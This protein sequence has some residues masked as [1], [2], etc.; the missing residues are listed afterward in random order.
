MAG[1]GKY[2]GDLLLIALGVPDGFHL[3]GLFTGHVVKAHRHG[4]AF[5][6]P[7]HIRHVHAHR[8]VPF[9]AGDDLAQILAFLDLL[10]RLDQ[11]I[12][13]CRRQAGQFGRLQHRLV[14]IHH[15]GE[16]SRLL[17]LDGG[18]GAVRFLLQ[19]FDLLA[20]LVDLLGHRFA[21][22]ISIILP[23]NHVLHRLDLV[24]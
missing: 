16:G 1:G 12:Q 7:L 6:H 8:I 19:L 5:M 14:A 10:P 13:L 21:A 22:L 23:V 17:G 15:S 4:H 11:L 18:N 9:A 24:R 20:Q 2:H 3:H